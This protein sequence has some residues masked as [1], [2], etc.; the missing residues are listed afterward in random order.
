MV[1]T[2]DDILTARNL[3]RPHIRRTPCMDLRLPDGQ[4]A[5]LKLEL[6]QHTGS[7][8][9]RGAFTTVLSQKQQPQTLV[10]ASGG[11]HGLAVAYVGLR[12]GIPASIFVPETA[13]APKVAR[14]RSYGAQVHQVG[15]TF[16]EALDA[17]QDEAD[18]PGALSV[19][20]YDAPG[21]VTGQGTIGVEISEQT[22]PDTVL[23]AVGGG[24]LIGGVASWFKEG[25]RIVG[26]EPRTCNALHAAQAAAGPVKVNPSGVAADSLG[27]SILGSIA[28][29]ALQ[30]AGAMSVLVDDEDILAARELLWRETR[31][32]AEPGGA[33][34]LAALLSGAYRPARNERVTVIVCGSNSDPR[35]LPLD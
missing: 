20:A 24:G 29:E 7:F 14:L 31:L 19:H 25:T 23:V 11:N 17:S 8:K 10:A 30:A 27:S 21:T 33:T 5:A 4:V 2:R 28:W 9:P 16:A 1:P 15:S 13:P 32:V 26:V 34:A 6:L 18:R 22:S 35:D 12:L 3:I